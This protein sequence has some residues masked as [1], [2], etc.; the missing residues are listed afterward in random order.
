MVW[1]EKRI[2]LVKAPVRR[3]QCNPNSTTY[4]GPPELPGLLW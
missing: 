2:G 4:T 3:V 1:N